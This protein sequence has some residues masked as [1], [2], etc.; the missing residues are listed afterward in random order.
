MVQNVD[1]R[2]LRIQ[3]LQKA[4]ICKN[5]NTSMVTPEKCENC[6]IQKI[7][8]KDNRAHRL[9]ELSR[10]ELLTLAYRM[11]EVVE[12]DNRRLKNIIINHM[13]GDMVCACCKNFPRCKKEAEAESDDSLRLPSLFW[14]CYNSEKFEPKE[15]E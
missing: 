4:R 13:D 3:D 7:Y 2:L 15:I 11:W 5:A 1:V 8:C 14:S 9:C 12:E 10:D 6:K